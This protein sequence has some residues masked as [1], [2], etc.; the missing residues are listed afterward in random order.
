MNG[1]NWHSARWYWHFIS[2][3]ISSGL[4]SQ[5]TVSS[6]MQAANS[7]S[8]PSAPRL[9]WRWWILSIVGG[10]LGGLTIAGAAILNDSSRQFV[11]SHSQLAGFIVALLFF[12]ILAFVQWFTLRR[13]ARYASFWVLANK[14]AVAGGA[15]IFVLG[16]GASQVGLIEIV[17]VLCLSVVLMMTILGGVLIY[18]FDRPI[19]FG[20]I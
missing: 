2:H 19:T 20:M 7:V 9:D 13:R 6:A 11:D 18:L 1:G 3:I 4:K 10:T 8:T 16:Q 12:G 15:L 5:R 17:P 14:L